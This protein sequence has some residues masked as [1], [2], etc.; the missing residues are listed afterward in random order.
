M[1]GR[2]EV[3]GGVEK[4]EFIINQ[5]TLYEKCKNVLKI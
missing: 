3:L 5:D 2:W 1:G 4:Q